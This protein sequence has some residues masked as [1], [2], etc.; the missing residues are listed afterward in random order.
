M[1]NINDILR[2]RDGHQSALNREEA[3]KGR[4]E[5]LHTRLSSIVNMLGN[6]RTEVRKAIQEFNQH[7]SSNSGNSNARTIQTRLE[8]REQELDNIIKRMVEITSEVNTRIGSLS[9]SIQTHR[10]GLYRANMDLTAAQS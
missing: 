5:T 6:G 8:Q 4:Y 9:T 3:L 2:R 1:A 7:Y 10:T